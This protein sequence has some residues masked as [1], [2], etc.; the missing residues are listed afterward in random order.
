MTAWTG[1]VLALAPAGSDEMASRLMTCLHP[2]AGRPLIWHTVSSVAAVQPA[3]ARIYVVTSEDIPEDLF[4]GFAMEVEVVAVTAG[5]LPQMDQRLKALGSSHVLVADACAPAPPE[6]LQSLVE[7]GAGRWLATEE[8][9]AAATWLEFSQL[10]QLFRLRDP[11]YPP[12]GVLAASKDL[13]GVPPVPR[14][15]NRAQLARVVQRVRD[16]NVEAL[17]RAGVTFLL[18]ETVIIDVDVRI[19]R[20][21]VVYPGVVL[22][23]QTTVGEETVIGPGC[24]IID[25][26]VGSGVEFKGWNYI[27]H[28][29]IRNRAILEPYVRR[30]F[31]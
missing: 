3:P 30:G 13:T 20:D 5:D 24:R 28:A 10:S 2:V 29:S 31:D 26:W 21:S 1:I 17:M 11:L 23:G 22:E 6:R 16:R 25:S 9:N 27:S 12:N 15:Q 7:Q 19:G 14:V 4:Q 8:G 18:P